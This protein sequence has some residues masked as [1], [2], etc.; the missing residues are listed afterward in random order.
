M[1]VYGS[2]TLVKNLWIRSP[3]DEWIAVPFG[4][5]QDDVVRSVNIWDGEKWWIPTWAPS[6]HRR[7]DTGPDYGQIPS[8]EVR[9]TDTVSIGSLAT[10]TSLFKD[11]RPY[12]W[13]DPFV[14][15]FTKW[16]RLFH[17]RPRPN[18]EWRILH[19]GPAY[20]PFPPSRHV[21]WN[22]SYADKTSFRGAMGISQWSGPYPQA[23]GLVH[24]YYGYPKQTAW[25][26]LAGFFENRDYD[27]R[28]YVDQVTAAVTKGSS[29]SGF[30]QGGA[31][32]YSYTTALIDFQA[33][34]ERLITNYREQGVDYCGVYD[35]IEVMNIRRIYI[36]GKVDVYAW[37]EADVPIDTDT[38]DDGIY[39]IWAASGSPGVA[40]SRDLPT[41]ITAP[42]YP[43]WEAGVTVRRTAGYSP[44]GSIVWQNDGIYQQHESQGPNLFI[45]PD[46]SGVPNTSY[47]GYNKSLT[48]SEVIT[49]AIEN[50][51][52]DNLTL[53][54]TLENPPPPLMPM[55]APIKQEHDDRPDD[56]IFAVSNA[57]ATL[58]FR[59]SDISIHY[60][61]PTPGVDTP[62]NLHRWDAWG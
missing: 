24:D 31:P 62:A 15:F 35:P 26:G 20:P 49:I 11:D 25:L 40:F 41:L 48:Y 33:I 47:L 3:T 19:I 38:M 58:S 27:E 42:N 53:T 55:T 16:T 46:G 18:P 2:G 61:V 17:V 59:I 13:G 37:S 1:G 44:G 43:R 10:G 30:Y 23:Q 4:A 39:T 52:N 28:D 12:P 60:A 54:A 22:G 7:L 9:D 14:P 32:S 57:G 29:N 8:L 45:F 5:G 21:S 6:E 56:E 50:P 36:R 34:R 51:G